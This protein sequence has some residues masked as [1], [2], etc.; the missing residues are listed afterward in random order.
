MQPALMMLT[1]IIFVGGVA[2]GG[3]LGYMAA[4]RRRDR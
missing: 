3:A 4:M 1:M 2:L